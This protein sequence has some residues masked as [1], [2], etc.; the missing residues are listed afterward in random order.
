[1]EWIGS[2]STGTFRLRSGPKTSPSEKRS[3]ETVGLAIPSFIKGGGNL[4]VRLPARSAGLCNRPASTNRSHRQR[5]DKPGASATPARAGFAA[6]FVLGTMQG[7][8][9]PGHRGDHRESNLCTSHPDRSGT[10]SADP[11]DPGRSRLEDKEIVRKVRVFVCLR[12][13]A[14]PFSEIFRFGNCC[15]W[16]SLTGFFY[17]GVG[18]LK[19][20]W[21]K[22]VIPPMSRERGVSQPLKGRSRDGSGEETKQF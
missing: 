19:G 14:H 6:K 1:V 8:A 10:R 2:V 15:G 12:A 5:S 9:A 4:Q 16:F 7:T 13:V 18:W 11:D 17:S 21:L 20:L 3:W 22:G